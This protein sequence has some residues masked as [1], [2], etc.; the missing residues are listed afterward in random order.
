MQNSTDDIDHSSDTE[1]SNSYHDKSMSS[2]DFPP[3][4][5]QITPINTK[6]KLSLKKAFQP[7]EVYISKNEKK[8][9]RTFQNFALFVDMC[10]SSNYTKNLVKD[11]IADIPG[12]LKMVRENYK[13]LIDKSTKIKFTKMTNKLEREPNNYD[14]DPNNKIL[15]DNKF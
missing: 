13:Y 4:N 5:T 9:L 6:R 2:K 8:C 1:N 15:S 10:C 12:L 11:F 3:N 7:L 14:S